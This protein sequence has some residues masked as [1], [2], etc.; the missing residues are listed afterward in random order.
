MELHPTAKVVILDAAE[1][2]GGV[3]A[4]H[5]LYPGLKSNNLWGTYEYSDF[6][7][8]ESYG[9][10][11]GQHIP[12]HVLH[13]YLSNY[14]AHFGLLER[15]RFK[16][17]VESAELKD[18]QGWLLSVS[19]EGG[20]G[21]ILTER[22]IVATG[23]TSQPSIPTWQGQDRF[24][25][26]IFHSKDFLAHADSLRTADRVTVLGGTKSG[27]DA[28]YAYARAGVA[29]D[30]VIRESGHG[31]IW[32]A[33]PYVTPL[34][35]WLEKLVSTRCLTWFSPCIWGAA[36]GFPGIRNFLH[37][38]TIGRKIVDTFWAILANDVRTLNGYDK[39]PETKKLQP[40]SNPFFLGAGLSILN[41]ETNFFDLVRN[42]TIK[43][44]IADIDSLSRRSVL[45][46]N[47][48]TLKTDAL[49]CATG[50]RHGPPIKFLPEGIEEDLG[51]PHF[52]TEPRKDVQRADDEILRRFPR[53][54][55]QPAPNPR[56]Q[57]HVSARSAAPATVAEPN[58]PFRLYRFMVPP[59]FIHDRNIAFAGALMALSTSLVA[60]TQA[61]WISAYFDGKLALP[62]N[63]DEIMYE[64]VLHSRFGK[65]R[66]P[67]GH[68]A[69][70]PDFVFDTVPYLDLMLTE[71]GLPA[72]R[73]QGRLA[74]WFT[75]Y[76]PE[77][78]RGLVNEWRNVHG[79]V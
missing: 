74:E 47:G 41:Y 66:Y 69:K 63:D 71:L 78:Y 59:A 36:D 30:M 15:I 67:A 32:M 43:V 50:W 44:H 2:V 34:K 23:L 53:L 75:P 52:S 18:G 29:V 68:G 54:R 16:T 57:L 21:Q 51:L 5:R 62:T 58:Q 20:R 70:F 40:W 13:R 10:K 45:L 37:G 73:K 31:P 38:T 46:S 61:L 42:G 12:G 25:A 64:T 26:P 56:A 14:A 7:M 77:H 17:T 4:E 9:V 19:S 39:H 28:A 49:L 55:D 35:K 72:H 11:P 27:W 8:N 76:G 24:E 33:P 3:W 6:P 22:L 48:I 79:Q 65:W 1:T 60:Q